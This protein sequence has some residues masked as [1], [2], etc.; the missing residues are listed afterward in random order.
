MIYLLV[1]LSLFILAIVGFTAGFLIKFWPFVW[2]RMSIE[3]RALS[4][5]I[6]GLGVFIAVLTIAR[7]SG[8]L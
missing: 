1:L 3:E 4:I 7:L 6:L 2:R 8:Y 5:F